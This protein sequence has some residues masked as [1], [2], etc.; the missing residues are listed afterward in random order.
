MNKV[1]GYFMEPQ[2]FS[3]NDGNGIRT[4]IFLAGCP[5]R[6]RWCSN[7]E[8]HTNLMK[9][10]HYEKTCINCGRC[11]Q[12]CPQ[13][14][15]INL[16]T[17]CEQKKCKACGICIKACP[18]NSRKN[19]IYHYSSEEI[20]KIIE[21]QKIFYR[22]SGGGVTFSGGEATMQVEMLRELVYKL[23]DSAI[24]LA[25]ET[26]GYFNFE[27]IKDILEKMNLIF[28]DIKHMDDSKHR[29]YTGVSNENILKNIARLNELKVPV[30]V[31]I[32]LIDG[33]NSDKENI[34]KAAK[35][36]K[37]SMDMPKI[38]LLPYHSFGDSKYEALGLEKPLRQFK[39]PSKEY[40][41][42]LYGIIE[43]Q[44]IDVVSYK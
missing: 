10:A 33:V 3:I 27:E 2:N 16:N 37:D 20:M 26:S 23:Y 13:G 18:T 4:I 5:L 41:E 35:F 34:R 36:V 29:F 19:L 15:G 31:R 14:V 17:Q 1:T 44:G 11:A 8:S 40:M 32:P 28:V 25:I 9:V 22:Y 6:C 39:T 12:L 38:E 24:D 21:K 7:P 30:V 42:E 43:S